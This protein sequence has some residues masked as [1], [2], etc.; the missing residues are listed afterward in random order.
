VQGFLQGL[1]G[2]RLPV[3]KD[4]GLLVFPVRNASVFMSVIVAVPQFVI[5]LLSI[6]FLLL[7]NTIR[8][9]FSSSISISSIYLFYIIPSVNL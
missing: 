7:Y 1:I 3:K 8:N 6:F 4:G 2:C 5:Y 9:L